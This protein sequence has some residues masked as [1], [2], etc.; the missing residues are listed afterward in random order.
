MALYSILQFLAIIGGV[1][2]SKVIVHEV[3]LKW[4]N[5]IGNARKN[6]RKL[7]GSSILCYDNYII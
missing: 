3:V 4:T 7:L 6:V 1:E 5:R 2:K